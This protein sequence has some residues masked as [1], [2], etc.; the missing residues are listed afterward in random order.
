MAT[1]EE[2]WDYYVA[3]HSKPA[4]RALH[5]V[6]TAAAIACVAGGLLTRRGSLLLAAPLFGY[7]PAWF[8]HFFIEKNRPATFTYPLWSLKADFIMFGKMITGQMQ[9]EVDRVARSK[10]AAADAASG[11]DSE[12]MS[13]GPHSAPN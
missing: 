4:T 11:S 5:A 6:G 1:F 3:E 9:A 13:S 12:A 2:F 10:R 7:G 8:S